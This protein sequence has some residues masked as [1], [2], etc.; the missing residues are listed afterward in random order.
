METTKQ[1]LQQKTW[2]GLV[3]KK[4]IKFIGNLRH[5]VFT[6]GNGGSIHIITEEALSIQ[7]NDIITFNCTI[8]GSMFF[9]SNIKKVG[10]KFKNKKTTSMQNTFRRVNGY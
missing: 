3:V 4:E 6:F 7:K 1:T 5:Y 2:R 8:H 9:A 10:S